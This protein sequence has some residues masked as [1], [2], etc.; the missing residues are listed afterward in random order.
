MAR[1]NTI[2]RAV[3]NKTH[4][5]APAKAISAE[6]ELRRTLMACLLW[7]DSFYE[8][9]HSIADR[10]REL[11]PKV[12]TAALRSMAIEARMVMNLRHAPLLLV[13]EMA[14]HPEHRCGVRAALGTVIQRADELCEFLSLY[15][16]DGKIPLAKSVQKGLADAFP[17]FSAYQLAKY[18]RD[19]PVKLRDVLFLCHAKPMHEAQAA[20]WKQLIDGTLESPDTWEVE[21]SK[22]KG[23]GKKASWERLLSE[24]KL[25]ALA[26]IRNLRNMV[27]V[28]V[29]EKLIRICLREMN[30]DRVLP[31]RFLAA[32]RH[33]PTFAG[34]LEG[35]ML[36]GLDGAPKLSGHTIVL[37][38]VSGSMYGAPLSEKSEMQR[39]DAAIG[40]AVLA[41]EICESVTIAS[42]SSRTVEVPAYRGLGLASAI[43]AS[44]IHGSTL[45]GEAVK[46]ANTRQHDRIIVITDEQSASA[47]PGPKGKGYMINV[48]SYKHGVGYGPWTHLDG[49]S[50]RIIDYIRAREQTEVVSNA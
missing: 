35:A 13:R 21:L 7:E 17:K 48:A 41:R 12:R 19:T 32:V 38:D 1:T 27:E 3:V 42:F 11:V 9:G 5:G 25:G 31:F 20:V 16:Q 26:L 39:A 40:L 6:A 30:T 4:E 18:N 28:G 37:V 22:G 34:E 44:Q 50:E 49:F 45:L 8:S 15:W 33:A 36:K 10:I 23:E 43:N 29:D 14:R 46:W 47:V 24:N 2:G